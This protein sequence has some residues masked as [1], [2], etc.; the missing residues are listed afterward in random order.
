[1]SEL[2]QP[3]LQ[4]IL[5]AYNTNVKCQQ[6]LVTFTPIVRNI[7]MQLHCIYLPLPSGGGVYK[8]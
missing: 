3:V 5:L 8:H 2:N 1:M 4:G 7:N 6:T